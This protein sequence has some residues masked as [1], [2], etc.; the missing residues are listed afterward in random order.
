VALLQRGQQ[1][2]PIFQCSDC[3][4]TTSAVVAGRDGDVAHRNGALHI[5]LQETMCL[6]LTFSHLQGVGESQECTA[7]FLPSL[8]GSLSMTGNPS[9]ITLRC[10][11][12]HRLRSSVRPS[13]CVPPARR[14]VVS[15]AHRR[16]KLSFEGL[17]V[18]GSGPKEALGFIYVLLS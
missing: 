17:G 12:S 18:K 11:P 14:S 5:A 4:E 15:A 3:F 9:L 1:R 8:R 16:K 6:T 10:K 7:C 13:A 2:R